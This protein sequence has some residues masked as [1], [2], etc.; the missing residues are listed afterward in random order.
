MY[1]ETIIW[2]YLLIAAIAIVV[3]LTIKN[4]AKVKVWIKQRPKPG[5]SL[6]TTAFLEM[7]GD[8]S[9]G[10]V[11]L[12]GAGSMPAIGRVIV[13]KQGGRENGYVE[14]VTTD[15]KDE[16]VTPG[17]KQVG[18][19][20]FDEECIIDKYGYIYRQQKG[21]RK[22]ELLGY[23]ARPSDPETPT[24]YGERTW[25]SLWLK[26]TLN[27]YLGKPATKEE[28]VTLTPE[29]K[30]KTVAALHMSTTV[31]RGDAEDN[32]ELSEIT[33]G[34]PVK[35]SEDGKETVVENSDKEL[36]T[37]SEKDSANLRD[38]SAAYG[39]SA[40]YVQ[41]NDVGENSIEDSSQTTAT[42]TGDSADN[43]TDESSDSV[44]DDDGISKSAGESTDADDS[45]ADDENSA[46]RVAD[47]LVADSED[48]DTEGS[49]ME[50][51]SEDSAE[52]GKE[53]NNDAGDGVPV[54]V[55]PPSK[56]QNK[57][58]KAKEAAVSAYFYG[59]H[60]SAKDYLPAEARACAYA[61]LS[62]EGR[63]RKYS[64]FYKEQPYG[65]K[66]T[67]LLSSFIYSILYLLLYA[68][69]V[70][71]FQM[72]LLGDDILALLILIALYFLM[73]VIVRMIKIDFIESSNSF[74]KKLDLFNKNLGLRGF[75]Y[76]IIILSIV[77]IYF[78]LVYYD[79]DLIPLI[80]AI[81][82]GTIIN[83]TLSGANSTWLISTTYN[84]TESDE[85]DEECVNNP[86]GDISRSYEWD[87]DKRYSTQELHGSLT[88]YFTGQEISDVR[89][90]NPFFAQR[91]DK[92]DREYILDMFAFLNEYKQ[93][94][95][96]VRYIAKY[97]N[98]TINNNNLTPM[99]KVQFTLDFIQEPNINF[100]NN[101][102][103]KQINNFEDYI[104]FPDETLY[105]K[106]GDYNSKSLLATM[107]FHTMGYNVMFLMSRKYQHSAVALEVFPSEL[108]N[109]WYGNNINKQLITHEGRKYIFCETTGDHF[110]IGM[111]IEGMSLDDFED[112]IVFEVDAS[113]E[114]LKPEESKTNIYNWDLDSFFGNTLH[115]NITLKF[116]KDEINELREMNPFIAYG[117][118]SNS[119]E[120]NVKNMH[121]ILKS[122]DTYNKMVA[123]VANYI[124]SEINKVGFPELDLLQ[125]TLNFCQAPNITYRIDEECESID[126]KKE[127]M[128]YPEETL[129]D[130]EGDCDCKSM[131]L[132]SLLNQ[133]GYNVIFMMSRKIKH[134][135]IA[136]EC[137]DEWMEPIG[138]TDE[139]KVILTHNGRRY[140]YL[141]STG[142]GNRIG[143]ITE[144]WSIKDF[145]TFVELLT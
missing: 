106:E 134:A 8:G 60:S 34:S 144:Q 91:K 86:P 46:D 97:I 116:N 95:A 121:L 132:A 23:C 22:K 13:A 69:N 57:K 129:Y 16:T 14:V 20:C 11:R 44:P 18:Y 122:E 5:A 71:V 24:I 93:F 79:M 123:E 40:S 33:K 124:K 70:G 128:R 37:G 141:E 117:F 136:V 54:P 88:L 110:S 143:H 102:N 75:N 50:N 85:D 64:E 92:S 84:D 6:L 138:V 28:S 47:G 77:A 30:E 10:E 65:W 82:T 67:A 21:K 137:K 61:L 7:D 109:G 68:V 81:V 133:L 120:T 29:K 59:F 51:A 4:L 90:C 12:P 131:L 125:F 56:D 101:K 31:K 98:N 111:S 27:V 130:K 119:Y 48:N 2:L 76:T 43:G 127:Y 126:F 25:R 41:K 38:D 15:I 113:S 58:I 9:A 26:C 53:E 73:W 96:R 45:S 1:I 17:Y 80:V 94:N 55:A 87:L 99:D 63:K 114:E 118:D 3:I 104:R 107:L 103:C 83:M 78:S 105:D 62:G 100:V 32:A 108:E 140:I 89:Q 139:E 35:M 39:D 19:L 135:A 49:A 112:K 142:Q 52:D 145:E 72:P 42:A 74:Q 66:D 36:V 115:G